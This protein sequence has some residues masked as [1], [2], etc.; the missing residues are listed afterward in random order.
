ML[1]GLR[2]GPLAAGRLATPGVPLGS[3]MLGSVDFPQNYPKSRGYLLIRFDTSNNFQKK[4]FVLT[5][6]LFLFIKPS[7]VLER[8]LFPLEVFENL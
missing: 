7:M 8:S 2:G 3:L 4:K 6:E 5:K 1:R